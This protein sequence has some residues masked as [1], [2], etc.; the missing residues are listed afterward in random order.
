MKTS[1]TLRLVSTACS[2]AITAAIFSAVISNAEQLQADG[3]IR[4]SH[5]VVGSPHAVAPTL[6]AQAQAAQVR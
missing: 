1:L 5:S 4:L 3:S 2:L 6:I